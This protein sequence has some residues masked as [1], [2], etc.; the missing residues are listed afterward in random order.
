MNTVVETKTLVL[1]RDPPGDRWREPEGTEI[2]LSLTAGLESVFQKTGAKEYRF[3][4][5]EGKVFTVGFTQ[6]PTP[7][8]PTYSIYGD[9]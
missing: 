9:E 2:F 8:P 4:A 7:K 1:V 3:S 5:A 6:T